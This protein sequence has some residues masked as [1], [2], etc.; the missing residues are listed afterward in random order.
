MKKHA[1][2]GAKKITVIIAVAIVLLAAVPGLMGLWVKHSYFQLIAFYNAQNNFKIAVQKYHQHWYCADAVIHVSKLDLPQVLNFNVKQHIQYGPIIFTRGERPLFKVA[3]VKSQFQLA[4]ETAKIVKTAANS[5]KPMFELDDNISY[6]GN[7][8]SY[9]HS[10]GFKIIFPTGEELQLGSAT[11]EAFIN[12]LFNHVKGSYSAEDITFTT[13]QISITVPAMTMTFDKRKTGN[14]LWIGGSGGTLKSISFQDVNG[15]TISFFGVSTDGATTETNGKLTGKRKLDVTSFMLNEIS[16]GPLSI[17]ISA[18]DLN[19]AKAADI[20]SVYQKLYFSSE[21][22]PIAKELFVLFPN[23]ITPDSTVTLDSLK[24][25]TIDGNVNINGKAQWPQA[26]PTAFQTPVEFIKEA[27]AQGYMRI[28]TSLAKQLLT[29]AADLR[30][31]AHRMTNPHLAFIEA[32]KS[33]D[34]V[35]KQNS[36]MM[37]LLVQSNDISQ[38]GASKLLE[39]QKD[40]APLEDYTDEL[41]DLATSH[42]LSKTAQTMLRKQYENYQLAN[43]SPE[44]KIEYMESQFS[45][46]FY[47]WVKDGYVKEDGDDYV[48]SVTY[49]KGKMVFNGKPI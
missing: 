21:K 17:Q 33:L 45:D 2:S 5:D 49:Q 7:Y 25:V 44:E 42:Q 12:P 20:D 43:L 28:S 35:L 22:M 4:S 36:I 9:F 6:F 10:N 32:P 14:N 13:P 48:V 39:Y 23:L 29:L 24:L 3:R 19:A 27:N 26:K 37:A 15:K 40:N 41:N 18:K 47:G 46:E 8:Y 1:G 38:A 16:L 30:L 11:G 34:T 31:V